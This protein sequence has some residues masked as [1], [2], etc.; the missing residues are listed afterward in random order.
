V[1]YVE[2]SRYKFEWIDDC[3]IHANGCLRRAAGTRRR[4]SSVRLRTCRLGRARIPAAVFRVG[5]P[6]LRPAPRCRRAR[7]LAAHAQLSLHPQPSSLPESCRAVSERAAQTIKIADYN[8][9][10]RGIAVDHLTLGHAALYAAVLEW[11]AR[12][13]LDSC[14]EYLQCAVDGIR[15]AGLQEFLPSPRHG[16]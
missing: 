2:D 11:L 4:H 14:R 8:D 12:D 6:L 9:W 10:L 7:R 13:Q 5:L 1:T 16:Y 15:H 3:T